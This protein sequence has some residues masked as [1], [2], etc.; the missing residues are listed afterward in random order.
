MKRAW[1]IVLAAVIFAIVSQVV[2]S[3][4]AG[5][6]MSFYMD[7]DFFPVWSKL[8]MPNAGPPPPSFFALSFIF[9]IVAG[10]IYAW[11]FSYATPILAGKNI[12]TRG[13][14]YGL[15]LSVITLIPGYMSMALLIN[16]PV[17]LLFAWAAEGLV[18]NLAGGVIFA[19][20]IK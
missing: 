14:C 9:S 13:L 17:A 10:I 7:P 19:A 2:H 1:Q 16:L 11:F 8:M 3:L 4:G 5:A 12:W 18:L 6:T 20:I 15:L